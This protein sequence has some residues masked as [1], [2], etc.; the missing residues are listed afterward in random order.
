MSK[1]IRTRMAPSPTG[2]LHVGSMA[3]LLKNYAWAKRNN[4]QFILRIEDTDKEREVPGAIEEIKKVIRDYGLDWDEGPGKGGPY[5]S[6]IQSERLSI[7]QEKAQELIDN[8]K[9]YY[10]FCSKERLEQVREEQRANKQA[11][12]Y[13]KHCRILTA[14]EALARKE[15]GESWVIRLKVPEDQPVV[16]NDLLR[17]EII[18]NSSEVDDQ[19]LL[20]SDGYPTYHL[21]VVVDD[22]LMQITHIMRGEEWI[23]SAPKHVLLYEAFGW[24]KPVFAHIPVF[25]NPDGK[26]KMSKRKGTVSSRSFLDRGYLPEAMLNFFMILGWA[27]ADQQ[28]VIS[29]AEY[30]EAFDP[31][32]VSPKSVAFDLQKLNWMNG[33]YIRKLPLAELK[34]RLQPFIPETFPMNKFDAILPLVFERL[35]TLAD[36]DELTRFFYVDEQPDYELLLKKADN[37]LVAKQLNQTMDFLSGLS[38]W[39]TEKI[40]VGMRELQEKNDWHRGQFFMMIRLAVTG[41]KATPPLFETMS[42]IGKDIV[43]RRLEMVKAKLEN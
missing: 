3:M 4:G 26:G 38:E 12:K 13:D 9:A 42:V 40:E 37:Q 20:K 15:A 22:Y 33:V 2:E 43:L 17:G 5:G 11:P 25:L 19:V 10:C 23:S 29:L 21:G 27:K 34:K 7:Y 1:T 8:G 18:I 32:D 16:I 39:T 30:I 41:R 28:E 36:I 14:D 35:V 31:K 6:Y 24:E